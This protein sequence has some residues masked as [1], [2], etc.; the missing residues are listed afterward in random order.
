MQLCCDAVAMQLCCNAV[1]MLQCCCYAAVLCCYAAV[2]EPEPVN[3]SVV[4]AVDSSLMEADFQLRA[5]ESD[6]SL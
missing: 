4:D 1:A 6:E 5:V 3:E 2:M